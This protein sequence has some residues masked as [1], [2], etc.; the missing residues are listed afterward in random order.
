MVSYL[1]K[2]LLNEEIYLEPHN[3]NFNNLEK[4]ILSKLN[5]KISGKCYNNG[6][7]I[8]NSLEFIKK[9]LGKIVNVNNKNKI[10]YKIKYKVDMLCPTKGDIVTCYIDNINKMGIIAYI[11]LSEILDSYEGKNNLEDSPFIIIVP[12]NKINNINEKTQR[13][14][15]DIYI[16]A[17]RIKH[18]SD[19]IQLVG[20][21]TEYM[22]KSLMEEEDILYEEAKKKI[23]NE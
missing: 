12:N 2:Q 11:K 19:K 17:V 10:E 4:M 16:K 6:Y 14:K 5:S 3:I 1:T 15:I 22:I 8:P 9:T 20:C 18:D 21:E 13:Q 23:Y 7:V